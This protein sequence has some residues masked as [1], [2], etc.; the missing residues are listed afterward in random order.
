MSSQ[1]HNME[2]VLRQLS[3]DIITPKFASIKQ[4]AN[5]ALEL[6]QNEEKIK[7]IEA[8]ELREICLQP[9]QLALESR[10]KKLGHTALAGIQ[11][12]FKDERFRSS[13]ETNEED[14]W[15][16]S[17]VLTVLAITPNLAEDLQVEVIKLLLNMTVT[18]SWCTSA[19]TIIKISQKKSIT[20]HRLHGQLP[21]L[22]D[23][24]GGSAGCYGHHDQQVRGRPHREGGRPG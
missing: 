18:A 1:S 5:E 19:N 8:W 3:R 7:T 23:G 13:I 22:R 21:Q 2:D 11:V 17:Q 10:A 12:M 9:L 6:L 16:P 15:L 24:A 4:T 20:T 14:K